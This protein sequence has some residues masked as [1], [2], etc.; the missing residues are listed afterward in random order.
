MAIVLG[1]RLERICGLR[2]PPAAADMTG[3]V[4]FE[5]VITGLCIIGVVPLCGTAAATRYKER[6][7]V[8]KL[9]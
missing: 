3:G 6:Q 2:L 1:D 8:S 7:R 5:L 9:G 4:V